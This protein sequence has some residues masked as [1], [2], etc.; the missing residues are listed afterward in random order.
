[1]LQEG[2]LERRRRQDL[3]IAPPHLGVRVL[4]GDDL[5]LLG[6]ADGALHGAAGLRQDGLEAGS[7]A[8]SD[9]AAAAV[10]EAEAH[11][12]ALEHLNER[13]LG[14]VELPAGGEEA[15]VLVAVRISQ[16]HLLD[17]A[18]ALEETAIA[19]TLED[20]LHDGAAVA[21]IGDRLEERHDVEIERAL[22]R[23]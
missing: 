14:A 18:A 7:A 19:G 1:R 11:A 6:D 2:R 9:R 13:D 17:I 4:A 12:V 3:E 8:A 20:R 15:P 16:H 23:P 21:Q 22:A 5:A 10:E